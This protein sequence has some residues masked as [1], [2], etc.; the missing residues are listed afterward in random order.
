MMPCETEIP[1]AFDREFVRHDSYARHRPIRSQPLLSDN[2]NPGCSSPT[3]ADGEI[4][5]L[6]NFGSANAAKE[7][8]QCQLPSFVTSERDSLRIILVLDAV[9]E[10]RD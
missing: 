10:K 3:D 8:A 1:T 6:Q 5:S 4:C 9:S 2:R 7:C